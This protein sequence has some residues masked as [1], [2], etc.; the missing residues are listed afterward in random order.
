MLREFNIANILEY[1]ES[2]SR[3]GINNIVEEISDM[4]K[5]ANKTVINNF[6]S[7]QY[8]GNKN[9]MEVI[10]NDIKSIIDE[11]KELMVSEKIN[12]EIAYNID[13]IIEFFDE[14]KY[15]LKHEEKAAQKE[16]LQDILQ[17]TANI[18]TIAG[19]I[20]QLISLL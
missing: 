3:E 8:K 5:Q 18:A 1:G 19:V 16:K 6:V 13:D 7:M 14:K 15:R 9:K 17:N 11:L 12:E 10:T 20:T 2:I 4:K